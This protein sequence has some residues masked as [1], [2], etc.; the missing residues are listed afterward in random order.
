MGPSQGP[1]Q[2]LPFTQHTREG[3]YID[4]PFLIIE[5]EG[6]KSTLLA[7]ALRLINKFVSTIISKNSDAW[8][9]LLSH[10]FHCCQLHTLPGSR[11]TFRILVLHDGA[12]GVHDRSGCEVL[13][14]S[15]VR[16]L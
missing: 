15:Y 14:K 8:L 7:Q 3:L 9:V 5:V 13:E 1:S 12:K 6:F 2:L 11:V 10:L 4:T 16:F